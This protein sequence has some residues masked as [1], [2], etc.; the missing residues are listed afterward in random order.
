ME[1]VKLILVDDEPLATEVLNS[2]ISKFSHLEIVGRF[3]NTHEALEYIE[4]EPVDAIFLDIQMPHETGL[5]F[6]K[7]IDNKRI[8]V[9]FVTAYPEH[10]VEAFDLDALDYLVKPVS[11]D[12]FKKS[13]DRLE[14]FLRIKKSKEEDNTKLE[15]GHIFVKADFKF[16][17][18]NYEDIIF[19][20]AFADYVKIHI[21]DDK[22]II[23]LQ[24]MK[25]MEATL[26]KDKFVRVHR[27]FIVA[28]NKVTSLSGTHVTIGNK[29]IP[30]GKNYK[31]A[32]MQ[33]MNQNNFLK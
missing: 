13:L 30:I 33:V 6:I 28:I 10:A 5:E 26:P 17:K 20:E 32:F 4:N 7:K 15:D 8:P 24:T 2:H 16:V 11:L 1:K 19:I 18:L 29:H 23:T 25:K 9:I 3:R 21:P 14:E 12:R 27:S 31:E 22:R